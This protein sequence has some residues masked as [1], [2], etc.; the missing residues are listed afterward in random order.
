MKVV[1]VALV[2]AAVAVVA[3]MVVAAA[4][5]RREAVLECQIS[6]RP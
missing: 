5:V 3:A 1:Q 4:S 2:E 6:I